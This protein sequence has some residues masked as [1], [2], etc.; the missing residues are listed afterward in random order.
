MEEKQLTKLTSPFAIH[1][2]SFL[3]FGLFFALIMWAA[4]STENRSFDLVKFL[5]RT[6]IY[7]LGI[8]L[9]LFLAQKIFGKPAIRKQ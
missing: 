5:S 1:L 9:A 6:L 3:V 7:G 8:T 2:I 4:D